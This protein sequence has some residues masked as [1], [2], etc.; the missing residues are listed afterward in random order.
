MTEELMKWQVDETK[1]LTKCKVDETGL[2]NLM[3][4]K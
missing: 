3:L 4:M 2:R 1:N